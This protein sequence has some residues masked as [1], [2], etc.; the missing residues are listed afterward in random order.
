MCKSVVGG[1]GKKKK[2][3][4][5]YPVTLFVTGIPQPINKDT[6]KKQSVNQRQQDFFPP[7]AVRSYSYAIPK[8]PLFVRQQI[9]QETTI[10]RLES[11]TLKSS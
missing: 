3:K 8:S 11:T 1:K 10:P 7:Y 5:S 2:S 9:H 6:R 4:R